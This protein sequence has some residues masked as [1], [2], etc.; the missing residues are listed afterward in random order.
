MPNTVST[1]IVNSFQRVFDIEQDCATHKLEKQTP[2]ACQK[3]CR[4]DAIIKAHQDKIKMTSLTTGLQM[5][6]EGEKNGESKGSLSARPPRPFLLTRMT[7]VPRCTIIYGQQAD[8][9]YSWVVSVRIEN[10]AQKRQGL[11]HFALAR[12]VKSQGHF[13]VPCPEGELQRGSSSLDSS[14]LPLRGDLVS[15]WPRCFESQVMTQTKWKTKLIVYHWATSELDSHAR[16]RALK[17]FYI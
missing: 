16:I 9:K 8:I 2:M 6:W 1:N 15:S 13:C 3:F 17:D 7:I 12:F 10:S 14:M 11:L 5:S 4:H